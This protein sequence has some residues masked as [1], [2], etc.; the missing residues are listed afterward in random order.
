M[1]LKPTPEIIS[2][3][4][5]SLPLAHALDAYC[6]NGQ[7]VSAAARDLGL[8]Y[9]GASNSVKRATARICEVGEFLPADMTPGAVARLWSAWRAR[10]W[11]ETLAA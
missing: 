3:W 10:Q 11:T 5:L 8:T 9:H 4:R 7:D 2:P 6:E 1:S